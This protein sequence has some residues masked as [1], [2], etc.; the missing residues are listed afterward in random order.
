M[1]YARSRLLIGAA[2][3]IMGAAQADAAESPAAAPAGVSGAGAS[4]PAPIYAKW[5]EAYHDD[6]GAS[7]SY[8]AVGSGAGIAR[9][10]AGS[11]DFGGTDKPLKAEDL[12]KYQLM[13]F[14]T[15]LGGVVPV[16]HIPGVKSGQLRLDGPLLADIFAA[17]VTM[18]N[19]P[20][21]K[22][23]NPGL[24]LPELPI[25]L[26]VRSDKSGTTFLWTSYLSAVSPAWK[27]GPGAGDQVKWVW[28]LKAE[29]NAGVSKLMSEALDNIGYVEYAYAVQHNLDIVV[30]KNQDGKFVSPTQAAFKAAAAKATWSQA[31][32]FYNVL[33]DQPG[34]KSWPITGATYL[35]VRKDAPAATRRAVLAFADWAYRKGDGEAVKLDYVPLPPSVKDA[36]RASWGPDAPGAH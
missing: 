29:G 23:M 24:D 11:V 10:E 22:A 18:W 2:A 33:V 15:V 16:I 5:S 25:T 32:G 21:I 35:L 36:I 30:L 13:Q 7:V 31:D 6:R 26:V 34:A 1:T 12:E 28:A 4:F 3:L 9:I 8:Q 19:D 27:A 14:P 20:R 17:K